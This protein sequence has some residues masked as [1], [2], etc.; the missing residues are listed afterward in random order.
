LVYIPAKISP[1]IHCRVLVYRSSTVAGT[2][3]TDG[4]K[5]NIGKSN[6]DE[7][8]KNDDTPVDVETHAKDM[9]IKLKVHLGL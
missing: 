3:G 7:E 6:T 2:K 9:A 5:K 8:D 1:H 4:T